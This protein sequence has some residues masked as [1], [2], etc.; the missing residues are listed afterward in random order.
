[1]R[2]IIITEDMPSCAIRGGF[3]LLPAVAQKKIY[4]ETKW[5]LVGIRVCSL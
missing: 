4:K 1:M 3:G 5:P 2:P